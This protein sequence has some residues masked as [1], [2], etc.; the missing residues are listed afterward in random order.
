MCALAALITAAVG[1]AGVLLL[2]VPRGERPAAGVLQRG[3]SA[4]NT[5]HQERLQRL[6][7][8]A[9]LLAADPALAAG[10]V[11][12]QAEP[13]AAPA[14]PSPGRSAQPPAVVIGP[15]EL[16][17][18]LRQRLPRVGGDVA[19]LLDAGGD[20]LARSD[21]PSPAPLPRPPLGAVRAGDGGEPVAGVW[22]DEG[23]LF[24]AAR[25]PVAP[26][27][28]LRGW[29]MV[30][31]AVD[32][33]LALEIE[34]AV[35][36]DAA[37]F[38]ASEIGPRL[39]GSSD[40]GVAERLDA[41][42]GGLGGPGG[43][44]ERVLA[45]G[46]P[47]PAVEVTVGGR[48]HQALVAPLADAAGDPA[49]A[50]VLFTPAAEASAGPGLGLALAG[51]GVGALLALVVTAPLAL[52]LGRSTGAAAGRLT[53]ATT[54]ARAGELPQRTGGVR[55]PL[56]GLAGALDRLFADLHER[57]ALA[58]VAAAAARG[59]GAAGPAAGDGAEEER[60]VLLAA[61]LRRFAGASA[62]TADET[63]DRLRRDLR[64]FAAAAGAHGGRF[65]GALGHRALASFHGDGRAAHALAAAAEA[66]VALAARDSAFDEG[67]PP[68]LALA[69]GRIAT[70]EAA[71]A[72]GVRRVA[73]GTPLGLLDSLLR[74]AQAGELVLAPALVRELE[75]ELG[76]AGVAV[77]E[78]PGVLSPRPLAVLGAAAA[79][80]V[81]GAAPAAPAA[82]GAPG[83]DPDATRHEPTRRP[84]RPA[85]ETTG[86][87]A[88]G[89]ADP[90]ALGPGDAL[91]ERFEV[92]AV[93]GGGA[94]GAVLQARD[95]ELG[96]VVAVEA[97]AP[98]KVARPEVFTRLD[99][100]LQSVRKLAHPGI[101][102]TYDY[103]RAGGIP[104][105]AREHV[106]GTSVEKLLETPGR[107]PPAAA[108]G[109]ARQLAAALAS[110]HR[111][112]IAHGRLSPDRLILGADGR[113]KITGFGLAGVL[114]PPPPPSAPGPQPPEGAGGSRGDVYAAAALLHRLLLGSWPEPGAAP[115]G[116]GLPEGL[117][118]ALAAALARDPSKRPEDGA[119]L[120]AAL[121]RVRA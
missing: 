20:L 79:A 23:R 4:H 2:A 117:A 96:E 68:A 61:D 14:R 26:D 101:A 57:E 95:R 71:L 12:V 52:A 30:G 44:L 32:D 29:V 109:L 90:A 15:E 118:P 111:D 102:R 104:F 91:G 88:P 43:V 77:T 63:L 86:A 116:E 67:E 110:A 21:D 51:L 75:G 65:E 97:L 39:V 19:L 114:A 93:L 47:V 69:G 13:V 89:A 50:V 84:G 25:A 6:E 31:I 24:Y 1:A 98:A 99:S 120:L 66:L 85:P 108:L 17:T 59:G 78:R 113:L 33:V 73:A 121:D 70:G 40:R 82:G 105:L 18:L 41:Q 5:F 60:A 10:L 45:G 27:F 87:A 103:G 64:R 58:A 3:F 48:S 7:L 72:D 106:P 53:A 37:F 38:A 22:E 76:R 49:G 9:R 35:G 28:T 56:A 81:A 83:R 94:E 115:A 46:G 34:R 42:V 8:A 112:G 16:S 62:G 119:A 100:P 74:E 54:A 55:G 11:A 36:A 92:L 80:K 107:L